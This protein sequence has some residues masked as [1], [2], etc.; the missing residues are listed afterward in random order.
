VL[1]NALAQM[2]ALSL[3]KAPNTTALY[4][5]YNVYKA[6]SW[7]NIGVPAG[8]FVT[9]DSV[10]KIPHP[11]YES[12]PELSATPSAAEIARAL[13]QQPF[14]AYFVGSDLKT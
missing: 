12:F 3:A 9:V 14:R 8:G 5:N 1:V 2:K 10:K 4:Q 11:P 6:L 13:L 7:T